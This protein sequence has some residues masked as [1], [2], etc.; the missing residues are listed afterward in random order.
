MTGKE[1]VALPIGSIVKMA[2]DDGTIEEGEI[3]KA[4]TICH[5]MWPESKVTNVIDT[6][7]KGWQTYIGWLEAE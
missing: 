6:N 2:H 4:G 7:A 1:L 3:I 5:I